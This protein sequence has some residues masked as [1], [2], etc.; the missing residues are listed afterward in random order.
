MAA[1]AFAGL[2]GVGGGIVLV[3]MLVAV[4]LDRHRSHATSLAAIVLIGVVGATTYGISGEAVVGLGL[5]IGIGGVVGSTIGASVMHRSSPRM[6]AAVFGTVLLLAAAQ[7]ITGAEFVTGFRDGTADQ[8]IVGLLVG[9]GAGFFAGMSGVGGGVIFVPAG[10]L[11]L[12]LS[13]HEAQGTSL[14]AII[15]TAIAG[16]L[17]NLRN[18]R[19]RLGDGL[20]VGLGGMAGSVMG[21][22]LALRVEGRALSVAFGLLLLFVAGRTLYRAFSRQETQDQ[23]L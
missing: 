14:V 1:G 18:R 15:L 11:L 9:L 7:M 8:A 4:G 21:A 16:S 20:A 2:L 22:Q 13:Q 12:G 17:V 3:P 5:T 23:P 6:L 10:V 19:L